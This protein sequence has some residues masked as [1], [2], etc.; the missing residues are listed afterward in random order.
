MDIHLWISINIHVVWSWNIIY[1]EIWTPE[2]YHPNQKTIFY[3]SRWSKPGPNR[4]IWRIL[5]KFRIFRQK[6]KKKNLFFFIVWG[7][8]LDRSEGFGTGFGWIKI[9]KWRKTFLSRKSFFSTI[10]SYWT[11]PDRKKW[12]SKKSKIFVSTNG[13]SGLAGNS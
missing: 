9:Q 11:G 8:F 12:N 13:R 5:S 7:V 4:S 6:I 10:G 1:F 3:H 2:W